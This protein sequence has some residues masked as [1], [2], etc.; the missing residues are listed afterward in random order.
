MPRL[1]LLLA[2][3]R[4]GV[5][6]VDLGV[7]VVTREQSCPLLVLTREEER[8]VRVAV[9]SHQEQKHELVGEV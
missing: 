9:I 7:E 4:S 2:Q 5:P 3:F 6:S 1:S 8:G